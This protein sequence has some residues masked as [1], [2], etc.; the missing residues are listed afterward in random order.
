MKKNKIYEDDEQKKVEKWNKK[1]NEKH[2]DQI[3]KTQR[4]RKRDRTLSIW[5]K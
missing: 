4:K 2:R 5:E 3:R 1:R